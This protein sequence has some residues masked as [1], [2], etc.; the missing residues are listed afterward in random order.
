M[1]HALSWLAFCLGLGVAGIGAKASE[2]DPGAVAMFREWSVS[3]PN[4]GRVIIC[5]GFSCTFRTEIVLT[6]ADH[7]KLAELMEPGKASAVAERSAI[8]RTEVWFE[9]RI[10]PET[11]TA[12]AKA[13]AGGILGYSR[14]RGQFDC[15]DSTLYTS[16]LLIL[17]DQLVLLRQHGVAAPISRLFTGGGPHFTAVMRDRKTRQ[18]WTV[19]PWTHNHAELPDVWP[20]EKWLAGG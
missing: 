18:G 5:H 9:K 7:A 19:D 4:P 15:I 11:G 10:A 12:N 17:L 20:V 16:S 2:L 3:L 8:A 13:R 1:R 14:D 6:R